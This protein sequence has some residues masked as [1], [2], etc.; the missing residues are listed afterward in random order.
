MDINF[1]REVDVILRDGDPILHIINRGAKYSVAKLM[2]N[3]TAERTW[4]LIAEFWISVFTG[5]PDIISHDQGRNFTAH[6]FQN[7]CSQLVITTEDTPTESYNSLPLYEKYH[8]VIRRACNKR[9]VDFPSMDKHILLSATVHAVNTTDSPHFLTTAMPFFGASHRLPLS[10][11]SSMALL[12]EQRFEAIRAARQETETI[13]VESRVATALK[14]RAGLIPH[15]TYEFGD[16]LGVWRKE[17]HKYE[18]RYI[19]LSYD[20][21]KTVK[22]LHLSLLLLLTQYIL[23]TKRYRP[24]MTHQFLRT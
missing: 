10:N 15:S 5:Y 21:R 23:M 1:K 13:T 8:S 9:K 22:K 2:P 19:V 11:I 17:A 16:K 4:D 3:Q 12:Q 14:H 7:S 24:L 6:F 20:D 18:G